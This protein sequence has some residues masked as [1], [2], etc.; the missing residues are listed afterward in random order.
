MPVTRNTYGQDGVVV[1]QDLGHKEV[2]GLVHRIRWYGAMVV[3]YCDH[4]Q[5]AHSVMPFT[6]DEPLTCLE[7]IGLQ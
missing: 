3:L 7:C 1:V 6:S 2:N 5:S 4:N